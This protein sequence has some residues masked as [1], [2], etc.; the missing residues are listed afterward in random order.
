MDNKLLRE[1]FDYAPETG[2]LTRRTRTSNRVK[3]GDVVGSLAAGGYLLGTFLGRR[4]YV[5]RLIWCWVNGDWPDK[6]IDHINGVRSDNRLSNLRAASRS[7]NLQNRKSASARS[8]TGLLGVKRNR[9]RFQARISV[10]GRNISL[11]CFA[12]AEMAH[13]AYVQA[14]REM[15]PFCTL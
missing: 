4:Y 6:D 13:A 12:T 3:I 1:Q 11:G 2:L 7:E 5:H 14:K 10:N 8:S 9:N 15:H